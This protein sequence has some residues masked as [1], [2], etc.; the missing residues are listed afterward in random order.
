MGGMLNWFLWFTQTRQFLFKDKHTPILRIE[1]I[2]SI[3]DGFIISFHQT[4]TIQFHEKQLNVVIP[5]IT[6]HPLCPAS[7]LYR[8]L[9]LHDILG[10]NGQSPLLCESV[11]K[12][13]SYVNFISFV[14]DILSNTGCVDKLTGH[15]FRR[16][17]ATFAFQAGLPGEW[18]QDIGMWKSN[19]YLRYIEKDLSSKS[20]A[21]QK[22]GEALPL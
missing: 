17:G 1:Q 22:F 10:S 8:L 6:G 11:I 2:G 14:N 12:S 18:K 9:S 3:E 16:D 21:L 19:A 20:Q 15:S 7:A 5:H 4:K 13:L